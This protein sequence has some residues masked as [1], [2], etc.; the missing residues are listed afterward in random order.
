[1]Q[2]LLVFGTAFMLPINVFAS[3]PGERWYQVWG[4]PHVRPDDLACRFHRLL[5]L[6][7]HNRSV[8][9]TAAATLARLIAATWLA[10]VGEQGLSPEEL[11]RLRQV[12]EDEQA[13]GRLA[14]RVSLPR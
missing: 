5:R 9:Y 1:M 12:A 2:R 4:Q 13:A 7:P 14:W 8:A 10:P 6:G 3:P 11:R